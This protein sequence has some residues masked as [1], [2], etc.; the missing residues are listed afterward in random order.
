[1]ASDIRIPVLLGPTA[2]GKTEL[3]LGLA[4]DRGWEIVS[5]DSRQIYRYMDIGTA[6]PTPRQ[7]AIAAHRMIDIIE[8]SES[9]SAYRYARDAR[10]LIRERAAAGKTLLVCGGT[11]LYYASLS[12]GLSPGVAPDAAFR[13]ACERRASEYGAAS[14]HDEL[15]RVD[16]Q[17]AG[18]LHPNDLRRVIRALQVYRDTGLPLSA[19]SN[20]RLP[21]PDMTFLPIVVSVPRQELYARIDARVERMIAQGLWDEFRALRQRGYGREA[22][23]MECLGYR[24]LMDVEEGRAS[25]REAQ[26]NVKLHT[27]RYAK[28]Q[29]TWFAHQC[30]GL[31]V[32]LRQRSAH[33][34]I[35]E[36]I[37][38]F[39]DA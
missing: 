25:M 9:Y 28:R 6:K 13:R 4:G 24:E 21:P 31:R 15:A 11:G 35:R 27:R 12:R 36:Y 10:A 1:M 8:P 34:R 39:L 29:V 3:A 16:P 23:G 17:T 7:R 38:R 2:A 37:G 5:C 22:P 20:E 14:V 30:P 32:D 26:E 18:R 33:A 19:R